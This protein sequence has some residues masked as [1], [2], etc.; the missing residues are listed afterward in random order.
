M[1]DE[2]LNKVIDFYK[3]ITANN[4]YNLEFKSNNLVRIIRFIGKEKISIE[5]LKNMD[6]FAVTIY[7]G[8]VSH[9]ITD[10]V[11]DALLVLNHIRKQL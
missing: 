10:D 11:E 1:T 6:E 8:N 7:W 5:Y 4:E 3:D 2:Q 9:L